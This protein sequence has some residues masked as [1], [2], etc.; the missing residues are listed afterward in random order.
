MSQLTPHPSST[1][2]TKPIAQKKQI[3]VWEILFDVFISLLI[4]GSGIALFW[5]LN[6]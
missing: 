6:Y 4:V 3:S 1:P 2:S 5:I